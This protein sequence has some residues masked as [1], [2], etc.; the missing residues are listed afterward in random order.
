MTDT[1]FAN[2]PYFISQGYNIARVSTPTTEH[3]MIDTIGHGTGE[4]ANVLVMVA[5]AAALWPVVGEGAPKVALIVSV[6][7]GI[8]VVNVIGIKRVVAVLGAM[9]FLKLLPLL[10]LMAWGTAL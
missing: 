10:I 3:P 1:G 2:H 4:S 8:T 6:L 5:Y 7:G 9:T